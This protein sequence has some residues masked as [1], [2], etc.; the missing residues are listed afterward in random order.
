MSFVINAEAQTVNEQTLDAGQR[1]IVIIYA[2]TA[3]GDLD[4]LEIALTAAE[5]NHG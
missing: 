4:K 2:F 5:R 1:S 3:N